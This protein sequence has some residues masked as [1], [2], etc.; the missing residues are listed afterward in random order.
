MSKRESFLVAWPKLPSSKDEL[1][2]F[3]FSKGISS[4][5]FNH[6]V[7]V[8]WDGIYNIIESNMSM[9]EKIALLLISPFYEKKSIISYYEVLKFLKINE[10]VNS[11]PEMLK[12]S[13]VGIV[14]H[15]RHEKCGDNILIGF[16][17]GDTWSTTIYPEIQKIGIHLFGQYLIG[18]KLS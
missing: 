3:L 14:S 16:S 7:N 2:K 11:H 8:I 6:A 5:E 17:F 4:N 1:K 18:G 10:Y 9:D 15:I 12:K 13:L